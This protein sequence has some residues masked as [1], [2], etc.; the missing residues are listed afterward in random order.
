MLDKKLTALDELTSVS[1]GSLIYIVDDPGGTPVSKNCKAQNLVK[2]GASQGAVA[3]LI[4]SVLTANKSLVSDINGK[5]TTT[6]DIYCRWRGESAGDP[7]NNQPGDI[8]KDTG[9][10]NK[11]K[12][13]DGSSYIDLT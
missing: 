4:D 8:Y 1:S 10:N 5:I 13:Y 2:G 6:D 7:G 3:N 12:I 11:I 9:D